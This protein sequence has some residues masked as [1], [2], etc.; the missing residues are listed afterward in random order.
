MLLFL[1]LCPII[2]FTILNFILG[3]SSIKVKD[4]FIGQFGI[5]PALIAYVFIGTTL[6]DLKDSA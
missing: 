3:T 1:R 6:S 2:P 5:L 4:Y